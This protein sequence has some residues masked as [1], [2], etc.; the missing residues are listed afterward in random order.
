MTPGPYVRRY[1]YTVAP[2][3]NAASTALLIPACQLPWQRIQRRW[4]QDIDFR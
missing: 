2:R 4:R 3:A 1:R